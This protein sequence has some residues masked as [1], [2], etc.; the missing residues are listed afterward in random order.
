M[1]HQS[2]KLLNF[3]LSTLQLGNLVPTHRKLTFKLCHFSRIPFILHPP[4]ASAR[5]V[6]VEVKEPFQPKHRKNHPPNSLS[7][8]FLISKPTMKQQ[9]RTSLGMSSA[10]RINKNGVDISSGNC[11]NYETLFLPTF[12]PKLSKIEN[13]TWENPAFARTS[14]SESYRIFWLTK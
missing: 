14:H 9:D 8:W 5:E 7:T 12:R 6:E 13:N 11:G 3:K 1:T 2:F 4:G 10:Q